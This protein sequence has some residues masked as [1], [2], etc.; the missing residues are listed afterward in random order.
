M[1]KL[2]EY[3]KYYYDNYS[4]LMDQARCHIMYGI[5]PVPAWYSSVYY[6]GNKWCD[7]ENVDRL[8]LYALALEAYDKGGIDK[9]DARGVIYG[10]PGEY[11]LKVLNKMKEYIL[12]TK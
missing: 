2:K 1:E 5:L 7:G 4:G 9:V 11:A 6:E 12:K 8:M 3:I 10:G